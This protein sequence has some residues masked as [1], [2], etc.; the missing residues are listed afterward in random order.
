MGKKQKDIELARILADRLKEVRKQAGKKQ[1]DV[2]Y[3]L[4]MNIGR[5]EVGENC[6]SLPTLK[7]LCEYYNITLEEFFTGVL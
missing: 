1:E 5:I 4:N 6:I 7:R 3:D 2:R